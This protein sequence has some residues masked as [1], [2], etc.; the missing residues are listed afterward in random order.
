[1]DEIDYFPKRDRYKARKDV[2]FEWNKLKKQKSAEST[3]VKPSQAP[4][5]EDKKK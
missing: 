4:P 2:G 3:K 5:K 1:M